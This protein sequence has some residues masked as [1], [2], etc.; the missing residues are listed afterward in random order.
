MIWWSAPIEINV[1]FGEGNDE[2][3]RIK[4]NKNTP[5]FFQYEND[6]KNAKMLTTLLFHS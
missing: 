5:G 1:L 4:L 6:I 2:E 3:K